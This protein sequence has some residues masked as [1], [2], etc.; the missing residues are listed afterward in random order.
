MRGV[1]SG[2]YADTFDHVTIIDCRYPYE[3]QGGHIQV[4][5]LADHNS[6]IIK[7]MLILE[8]FEYSNNILTFNCKI[9]IGTLMK[10]LP[11]FVFFFFFL[12]SIKFRY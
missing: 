12:I 5:D 2:D 9:M 10:F 7:S 11:L 3:Y 8:L 6:Y 4:R 1:L